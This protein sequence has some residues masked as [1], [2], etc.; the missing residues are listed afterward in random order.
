MCFNKK[1]MHLYFVGKYDETR[2]VV[3]IHQIESQINSIKSK[4]VEF[5]FLLLIVDKC[6][7]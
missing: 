6:K 7:K 5:A 3:A 4:N 1:H 2:L